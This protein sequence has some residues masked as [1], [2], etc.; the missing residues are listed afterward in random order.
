MSWISR[1]DS[2]PDVAGRGAI[3]NE[4]TPEPLPMTRMRNEPGGMANAEEEQMLRPHVRRPERCP[5]RSVRKVVMKLR[6]EAGGERVLE[7]PL[8]VGILL[9][10]GVLS[11]QAR[12]RN[13]RSVY[14][15]HHP[16]PA[17]CRQKSGDDQV[18]PRS[19]QRLHPADGRGQPIGERRHI[20]SGSPEG[21]DGHRG[22]HARRYRLRTIR[23][24][25]RRN[26]TG[27]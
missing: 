12:A 16:S 18:S 8:D 2:V 19:K 22:R 3:N 26:N 24:G 25:R 9:F 5:R 23:G 14:P 4:L 1:R 15:R 11:G 10:S 7:E 21:R 27:E 13:R 6:P 17:G 20:R